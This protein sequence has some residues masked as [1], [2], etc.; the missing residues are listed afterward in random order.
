MGYLA[1]GVVLVGVLGL[2]NLLLTITV[3]RR[4]RQHPAVLGGASGRPSG[5]RLLRI[6]ATVTGFSSATVDGDRI[7]GTSFDAPTLV[8]FFSTDCG[9]CTDEIPRLVAWLDRHRFPRTQALAVVTGD[10]DLARPFVDAL[11]ERV[12]LVVEPVNGALSTAFGTSA[13]PAC[14]LIDSAGT[15]LAAASVVDEL[16]GEPVGVG[17]PPA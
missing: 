2:F 16:A 17:G 8:A 15:V 6:G 13:F 3:I 1:A 4:L 11:R 9:A 12:A 7:T 10:P 14:Y 5:D